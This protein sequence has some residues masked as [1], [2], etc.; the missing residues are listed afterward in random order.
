VDGVL[1]P[2]VGVRLVIRGRGDA[3]RRGV[4]LE[5]KR[6]RRRLIAGRVRAGP[7]PTG[8]AAVGAAIRDG[9]SAVPCRDARGSVAAAPRD[10]DRILVPAAGI[11]LVIRGCRDAWRRRVVLEQ[12]GG[13]GRIARL[14]GAGP[15][16]SGAAA[17]GAAVGDGR[18]AIPG[19]D[20]RGG[21][22]A[23]PRDFDRILVP[24]VG[25]RLVIRGWRDA[26]RRGVVLE[27]V[28]NRP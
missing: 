21:V 12:D 26:W 18:G 10:F 17:V 3:W 22:A 7:A 13:R 23:A 5:H 24:A 14:I 6:H 11:R 27:R 20:A 1:V 15:A 19:G 4:V 28:R 16:P 9:G 25:V 2:A 8:A